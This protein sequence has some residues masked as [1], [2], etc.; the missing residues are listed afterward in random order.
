[1]LSVKI[2][3]NSLSLSVSLSLI[4]FAMSSHHESGPE[5]IKIISCSTQLS[6][7]IFLLMNVKMPT[8][9][10]ILTF[11]SRKNSILGLPEPEQCCI[12]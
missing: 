9:V 4:F 2:S 10:G 11:M 3:N 1:M 7:N 8:I 5:V 12:S 6:M